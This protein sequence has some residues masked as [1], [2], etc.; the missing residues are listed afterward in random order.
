MLYQP[1]SRGRSAQFGGPA[2]TQQSEGTAAPGPKTG[3]PVR[4]SYPLAKPRHS[5]LGG[6]FAVANL[7]GHGLRTTPERAG[8][9]RRLVPPPVAAG[10]ETSGRLRTSY[11]VRL[12]QGATRGQ[13]K[14]PVAG[15]AAVRCSI[16]AS[17]PARRLACC[18]PHSRRLH[19][20]QQ[21]ATRP[22]SSHRHRCLSS[23]AA[24]MPACGPTFGWF[25]NV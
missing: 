7:A 5:A 12:P 20:P 13:T 11:R 4:R 21:T 22:V 14:R 25:T 24:N 3:L 8:R 10:W 1:N 23:A 6:A 9:T 19:R 2:S 17:G 16:T 15:N 18:M